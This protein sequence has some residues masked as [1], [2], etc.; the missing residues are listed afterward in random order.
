MLLNVD[1]EITLSFTV[2]VS[3]PPSLSVFGQAL[4]QMKALSSER[5]SKAARAQVGNITSLS[6]HHRQTVDTRTIY[7][8][9]G[10][11]QTANVLHITP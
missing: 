9:S 10:Q 7:Y 1:W 8:P 2:C 6:T 3:L 11:T 5:T 4:Q